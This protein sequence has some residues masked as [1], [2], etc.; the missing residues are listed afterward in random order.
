[1]RRA[2]EEDKG[3][4]TGGATAEAQESAPKKRNVEE[5]AIGT[6]SSGA[7]SRVRKG[8]LVMKGAKKSAAPPKEHVAQSASERLDERCRKK[9]DRHCR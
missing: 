9:G 3:E 5:K 7:F 2:A 6:A 8:K 4:R 1:M